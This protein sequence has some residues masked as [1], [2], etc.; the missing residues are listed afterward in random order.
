MVDDLRADAEESAS[1]HPAFSFPS[2]LRT[3]WKRKVRITL[4]W[5]LFTVCALAI[6]RMLPAV[7]LS[8]ALILIDSQK[9]PEKFVSSTVASDLED[10]IATI[11]EMLL[12]SGELKKII[13][14]FGLYKEQRKS[15]FEE[16]ILEM[17]RKDIS[18][19]LDPIGNTSSNREKRTA[20][21][22]IGYQ[23]SDPQ[24]VTRV[25]NRLTDL[26]VDQ[27][28]KT[29]ESQAAGTSEF[30]D[31][32]LKEAKKRLDELEATVSS[33]KLAHNGE[34]PQQE[35]SLASTLSRLQIELEANRDAINRAQ[36]TRIILESNLSAMEANLGAQS[37]AWE[38]TQHSADQLASILAPDRQ[39]RAPQQ[40]KP[41]ETLQEELEVL[42]ARY[43][44]NHPDVIRMKAEIEKVKRSE[45]QQS[46]TNSALAA[47]SAKQL[48]DAASRRQP[49]ASMREPSEIARTREQLEGLRSQIRGSDKELED[50]KAEQQRILRDLNMYQDRMERL[51]VR[52]Q[53]MAQITRDYEMS[54]ENYKSLLDKKLAAEMAL[55][56]ERRQQSERFTVLDRAQVPGK[57]VKPNRQQLYAVGSG[58]ALVVALIA[59]F[60]AEMRQNVVLGEWELPE[61]TVVLAQLPYIEASPFSDRSKQ[62]ALSRRFSRRK[63]L[64]DASLGG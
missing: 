10:R 49:S 37:R 27:N 31:T 47:A 36:Q 45:Q 52:E 58:L 6:V 1:S 15:H 30:L 43:L 39:D 21:F 20:A 54:K 18:I 33:Y 3:I 14:D 32:Q 46:A 35:Q 13:D 61:G 59:G 55:D 62:K 44:E 4:V 53:E 9:I 24:L 34:L 48:A 2:I 12:S 11:R 51:P 8:Q 42:R 56:M 41:S 26:Y 23:G 29:R 40:K 28:L 16:E 19:T 7:Y 25:A 50:S 22:R 5:V 60:S 38:Q 64:A 57:P 17:M 63:A